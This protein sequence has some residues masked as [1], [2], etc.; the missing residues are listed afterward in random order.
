LE[1]FDFTLNALRALEEKV[2]QLVSGLADVTQEQGAK[3]QELRDK[4]AKIEEEMAGLE[5]GVEAL[6][7]LIV[8]SSTKTVVRDCDESVSPPGMAQGGVVC[9]SCRRWEDFRRF[10]CQP[11]LLAFNCE[12]AEGKFAVSAIKGNQMVCFEGELPGL[13]PLLKSWLTDQLKLSVDS[14]VIF[15][16]RI[17]CSS[18]SFS[19]ERG[20]RVQGSSEGSG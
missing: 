6:K 15:D 9:L 2:D 18:G 13:P 19:L 20:K 16:G 12:E 4:F 1:V 11:R 8:S 5:R 3:V 17:V 10:A 7:K 14:G